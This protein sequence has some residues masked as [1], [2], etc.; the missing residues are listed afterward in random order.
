MTRFVSNY[1]LD[2]PGRTPEKHLIPPVLVQGNRVSRAHT[3]GR[4]EEYHRPHVAGIGRGQPSSLLCYGFV[5]P[6]GR[7]SPWSS[8]LPLMEAG[9]AT[10]A[11]RLED[12]APYRC[13]HC[14]Q[15][16]ANEGAKDQRTISLHRIMQVDNPGE[17]WKLMANWIAAKGKGDAPS[18]RARTRAS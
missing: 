5:A 4:A 2:R 9:G 3:L 6:R 17:R 7:N 1:G 8:V 15:R 16:L 11:R 10:M 12:P 14:G 13:P 18:I